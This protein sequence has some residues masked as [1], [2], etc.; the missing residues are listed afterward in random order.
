MY[1]SS[2]LIWESFLL[3]DNCSDAWVSTDGCGWGNWMLQAPGKNSL[4]HQELMWRWKVQSIKTGKVIKDVVVMA[5]GNSESVWLAEPLLESSVKHGCYTTYAFGSCQI[6]RFICAKNALNMNGSPVLFRSYYW[7]QSY[8]SEIPSDCRI[9]EATQATSAAPTCFKHIVI[10]NRQP[11][12]DAA[13]GCNNPSNFMVWKEAKALF[14]ACQIGQFLSI[15]I[16]QTTSNQHPETWFS[17]AV[18][19]YRHHQGNKACW[20]SLGRDRFWLGLGFLPLSLFP[21]IIN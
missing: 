18:S 17:S 2:C 21:C 3:Q 15:G 9:W 1:Y 8:T 4:L 5:T 20:I 11:Y 13:I 14:E 10:G 16:G 19:T 12:I 7:P 6:W